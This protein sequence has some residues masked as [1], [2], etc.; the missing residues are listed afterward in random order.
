MQSA[1]IFSTHVSDHAPLSLA[2]SMTVFLHGSDWIITVSLSF[3]LWSEPATRRWELQCFTWLWQLLPVFCV[4]FIF[5]CPSVCLLTAS[6]VPS[7]VLH[8]SLLKP[9]N[10]MFTLR[11]TVKIFFCELFS[12]KGRKC[13]KLLGRHL[14]VLNAIFF[15]CFNENKLKFHWHLLSRGDGSKPKQIKLTLCAWR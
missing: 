14:S 13:W 5:Y 2:F 15:Q 1:S 11:V 12:S 8:Q 9:H 7:A 3:S 6:P 4:H 10:F